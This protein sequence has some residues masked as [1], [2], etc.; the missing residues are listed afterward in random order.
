M[1]DYYY[2]IKDRTEGIYKEKG[3]KFIAL[4]WH[5]KDE[6]NIKEILEEVKK[7]YHDARHHCYAWVL[8]NDGSQTR[9]NDDGE[10]NNSAG[11]PILAQINRFELTYVMVVV[12]RYFGGTLL[13][14]GGLINAYRTAAQEALQ[15]AERT[16][17][18]LLS[19]FSIKFNYPDMNNVMR[20]LKESQALQI[21]Q[22]FHIS[23]SIEAGIRR[24]DKD[25]FVSMFDPYPDVEIKL[26]REE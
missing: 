14:V 11:K 13:G 8:G 3:S 12:I 2:T 26:L 1:R 23:C 25:K 20:I 10:P 19:V 4:T 18:Y 9:A 24:K 15:K 7:E 22:D 16:K 5:V 21:E 17:K 6:E